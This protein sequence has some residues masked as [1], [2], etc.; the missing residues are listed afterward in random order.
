MSNPIVNMTRMPRPGETPPGTT[1]QTPYGTV[2]QDAKDGTQRLAL[3][4]EGKQR[5]KE[6]KAKLRKKLGAM[7]GNLSAPG[8][9]EFPIELGKSNYNPFTG[10]TERG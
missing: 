7:P 4:P 3:S 5:Y 2:E 1:V 6:A 8:M 10:R 9:P